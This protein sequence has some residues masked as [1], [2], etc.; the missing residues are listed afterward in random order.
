[1]HRSQ[2]YYDLEALGILKRKSVT[3]EEYS[4]FSLME[5]ED[6]PDDVFWEQQS[7]D[8]YTFWRYNGLPDEKIYMQ[9]AT[10]TALNIRT[11]KRASVFFVILGIIG[12]VAAIINFVIGLFS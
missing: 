3:Y 9:L 1:M 12:I 2:V 4:K 7:D 6:L 10:M 5:K 11:I 8:K